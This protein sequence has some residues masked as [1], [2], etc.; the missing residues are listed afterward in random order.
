METNEI[1]NH[2]TDVIVMYTGVII[3]F[4]GI[5]FMTLFWWI[6]DY[7]K[8]LGYSNNLS[9]HKPGFEQMKYHETAH[10]IACIVITIVGIILF[11]IGKYRRS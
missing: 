10:L 7:F 1:K 11:L 4:C 2:I 6:S 3:T 5:L 9:L 8:I